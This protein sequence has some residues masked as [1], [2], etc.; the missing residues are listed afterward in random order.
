MRHV[1]AVVVADLMPH[2]LADFRTHFAPLRSVWGSRL[3]WFQAERRGEGVPV[4]R[5]GGRWLRTGFGGGSLCRL[6]GSRTGGGRTGGSRLGGG[7]GRGADAERLGQRGPG[8]G[9]VGVVHGWIQGR[10]Q[11]GPSVPARAAQDTRSAA[12]A[13]GVDYGV[14]RARILRIMLPLSATSNSGR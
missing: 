10:G 9:L 5:R 6:F 13:S 8:I 3:L 1:A 4:A 2:L 11:G 14:G 12:A 7:F